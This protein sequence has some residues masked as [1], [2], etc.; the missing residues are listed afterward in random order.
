VNSPIKY[1]RSTKNWQK[2]LGKTGRVITATRIH[3]GPEGFE[4]QSPYWVGIIQLENGEKITG[5]IKV[6]NQKLKVKTND[7]VV[8]VLRISREVGKDEVVEYGVKW[9]II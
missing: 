5:Q 3:S 1:W 2:Y 6:K 7:K 9:K 8:G 4:K